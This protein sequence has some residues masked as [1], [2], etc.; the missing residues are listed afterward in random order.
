MR[1][2]R[3]LAPKH[4]TKAYY[5]CVSRVVNREFVL[6][7]EEKDQ[8]IALMRIY[9]ALYG[10]K[11]VTY[12]V[13]SNHFHVLVEVPQRPEVDMTEAQLVEH[14]RKTMGSERADSLA[15]EFQEFDRLGYKHQAVALK[16]RWLSRMWDVSSFMKVL[17]QRFT[18]W[19]NKKHGR[20][21]TLWEDR[22]RSTLVQEGSYALKTMAA[23]ID[24]NPVRANICDDPKEYRWCGYAAAVAGD[25]QAQEAYRQLI[26]FGREGGKQVYKK[27][28]TNRYAIEAWRRVLF[29]LPQEEEA[30]EARRKVVTNAKSADT[31]TEKLT[32]KSRGFEQN[33]VSGVRKISREKALQVLEEGGKLSEAEYLR[34]KVRYFCD[35]AAIGARGFVEEVFQANR[36][37][38][39]EKRK[40]GSR[41]VK[42][43]ATGEGKLYN[44]RN[45]QKAVFS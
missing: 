6:Q 24:L 25:K 4:F 13:M 42:G 5:H 33:A 34:C 18:Q 1:R 28:L 36:E 32:G 15:L 38:F 16:E 35:G 11:V 41:P 14:V 44:L 3:L 20:R 9:E 37:K 43:L 26:A 7:E 31:Y 12:C 29:G 22:F 8:F 17:K 23:Y 21:G 27:K 19:F 40:D 30:V 2:P 45:L 10:L 39:G